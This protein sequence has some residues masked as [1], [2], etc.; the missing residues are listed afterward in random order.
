MAKFVRYLF[1]LDL[2][3][4]LLRATLFATGVCFLMMGEWPRGFGC[5][6]VLLVW[7]TS[8]VRDR[9]DSIRDSLRGF[10][11]EDAYDTLHKGAS[12]PDPKGLGEIP[13]LLRDIRNNQMRKLE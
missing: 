1:W 3:F 9:L 7:Q 2:L 8:N 12:L 4:R 5:L 6:L 10:T 11:D 13:T